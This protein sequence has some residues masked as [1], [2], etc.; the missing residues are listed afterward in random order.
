MAFVRTDEI[1]ADAV[2]K[3]YGVAMI[4]VINY[5]MIK[6][7]IEAAEEEG[8]PLLIGLF[9]GFT[10]NLDMEACYLLTKMYAERVKAPIAIHLDHSP[11]LDVIA[12]YLKYY[13]S[14]MID[15]SSLP[16]EENVKITRE[17][18]DV[19]K[20]MGVVVEAELGHVGS[21][22]SLDDIQNTDRYTN[23]AQAAEFIERTGCNALAVAIGNAHGNYI[24]TPNLD[25]NRLKEI[26]AAVDIPLVLHGGS[27]IP[28][29]QF[30][31]CARIGMCKFNIFTDYNMVYSNA[32]KAYLD[33]ENK[34]AFAMMLACADPCRELIRHKIRMINPKGIRVV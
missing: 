33:K 11:S 29:E 28:D 16:Y 18:V 2:K 25:F 4:N 22:A 5:E 24:A 19:C 14:V 8:M 1:Y 7:A 15:G 20:K 31:E 12:K 27:G 3:G 6:W 32:C 9:P 23:P 34:G 21:G 13:N 17:V 30:T 26:R 10:A